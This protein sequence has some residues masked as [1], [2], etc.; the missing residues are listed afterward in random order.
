MIKL[1][2]MQGRLSPP[3]GNLIQHFPSKNWANEF[4]L[5]QHLG[6]KSIEWVFENENYLENPIFDLEKLNQISDLIKNLIL[7]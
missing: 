6:L 2:V 7:K 4:K 5:C 3:K 1:G